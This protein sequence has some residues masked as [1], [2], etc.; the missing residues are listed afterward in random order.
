MQAAWPRRWISLLS[1][2][3][4]RWNGWRHEVVGADLAGVGAGFEPVCPPFL[5]RVIAG[6]E[7]GGDNDVIHGFLRE[8]RPEP[9]WGLGRCPRR[10]PDSPCPNKRA[11]DVAER[12]R[13]PA[14]SSQ[15]EVADSVK[16]HRVV[17]ACWARRAARPRSEP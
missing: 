17:P 1:S 12:K 6:A 14:T 13:G 7:R 16:A 11:T 4:L 2:A 5:G 15:V 8:R 9:P 10:P 3:G